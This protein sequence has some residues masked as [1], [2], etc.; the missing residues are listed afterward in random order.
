MQPRQPVMKQNPAQ[1]A[2]VICALI[3]TALGTAVVVGWNIGSE[4]LIALETRFAA[5]QY[6]TALA[7][8]CCS[9]ALL[10]LLGRRARLATLASSAAFLLATATALE[11]MVPRIFFAHR[12]DV[13]FFKRLVENQAPG[14]MAPNT[15]V[16]FLLISVAMVLL[17][18]RKKWRAATHIAA[19]LAA[20]VAAVGAVAF[21]GYLANIP[22]A[23]HWSSRR[24]IAATTT[25]AFLVLAAGVL[26]ATCYDSGDRRRWPRWLP[27]PVFVLLFS[28]SAILAKAMWHTSRIAILPQVRHSLIF[29]MALVLVFG[30][31]VSTGLA[32]L[33]RL[34]ETAS[35]RAHDLAAMNAALDREV[36]RRCE[37]QRRTNELN[38]ALRMVTACS[39]AIATAWGQTSE[40]STAECAPRALDPGKL[41]QRV[42]RI[43]VEEGG[44]RLAWVGLAL[45]DTAKS[46]RIAAA[47]GADAGYLSDG[48]VSW[49]DEPRGRG[50]TG[51]AIRTGL[52]CSCGDVLNDPDFLPWRERASRFGFRSTLVIPMLRNGVPFAA[53]SLYATASNAFPPE[54]QALFAR[55]V[56]DLTFGIEALRTRQAHERSEAALAASEERY[57]SLTVA[58]AQVIWT[59]DPNGMV[60]GDLPSWRAFTGA[61]V[62]QVQGSGWLESLHPDDREAT[63][64]IWSDAV[65]HRSLYETEY[66]LRRHDGEYRHVWVRGV[67]VLNKGDSIREWVGTCTDITERKHIQEELE[68]Y[69]CELERSN[70][71]LQEFAFV[72]SH[73]LQEPLRKITAFSERL[74]DRAAGQLDDTG[75]DYLNR[76]HSAALRMSALINSLLD[77]SRIASR[78]MPFQSVDLAAMIFGILAD[79]EQRI[80]ECGARVVV[81]SL[82]KVEGDP[83]QLRQLFQN[84]LANALKFHAPG[85]HPLIH[86]RSQVAA[87][88]DARWKVSVSD[89]GIGFDPTYAEK[90]FR[91]FQRLHGRN[92]YEGSGMGLAICRKIAQRHG[93]AIEVTSAPGQGSTFTVSL[94]ACPAAS[95]ERTETCPRL[96]SES[97]SPKTMMTTTC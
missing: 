61:S 63:A 40:L 7:F 67:P 77:Y 80:K 21:L 50:P 68:R 35:S 66:R 31:I 29:S 39:Q 10:A 6:N 17:A 83:T 16:A 69:A 64:R 41:L 70:T 72:A 1:T 37:Q 14:P 85:A 42:C 20:F 9:L 93:A 5:V 96:P 91:P 88:G 84:L 27:A 54:E 38:R 36:E 28:F 74:R 32:V 94:P 30:A 18:W 58:T 86:V 51:T 19:S 15:V 46:V 34:A 75:L 45:D 65:A 8:L 13:L 43:A 47:A 71:E 76:M 78:A 97:S 2:S 87:E 81:H 62:A 23:Y 73:D 12:L 95:G 60:H 82:P 89:D 49:A 11:Y 22:S 52:V 92:E 24:P 26:A 3:T 79:L 55:L 53:F 4:K 56:K 90:I 57:R 25:V 44:Y 59:T 48:F 33:I